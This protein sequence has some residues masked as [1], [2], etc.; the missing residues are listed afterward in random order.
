MQ[1]KHIKSADIQTNKWSGGTTTEL[2]IYPEGATYA[3]RDFDV[4]ISTATIEVEE[5]TFTSLPDFDRTLMILAGQIEICHKGR[6][7]KLLRKFEIDNF[8]GGWETT[9]IGTATDFNVM[10]SAEFRN[11]TNVMTLMEGEESSV[12]RPCDLSNVLVI[13]LYSGRVCVELS[14]EN[15]ILEKGDVFVVHELVELFP[16][17]SLDDSEIVVV[18]I[19]SQEQ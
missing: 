19:S 1:I 13:Y 18:R 3:N 5:S 12:E 14:G 7:K 8:S 2:F 11:D 17:R 16:L 9:S 15:I 4:R 10:T 6:Y